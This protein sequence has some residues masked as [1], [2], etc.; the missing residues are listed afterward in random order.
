MQG[1]CSKCRA[2][3][4]GSEAGDISGRGERRVAIGEILMEKTAPGLETPKNGY[5]LKLCAAVLLSYTS[6]YYLLFGWFSYSF[7]Q[8]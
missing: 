2:G 8:Y 7:S 4:Q 6:H 1:L 3:F 5:F